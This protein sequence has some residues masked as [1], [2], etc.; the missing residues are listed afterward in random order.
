MMT[1]KRL[2]MTITLAM[3]SISRNIYV[4][5]CA[6]ICVCV[7]VCIF[8]CIFCV[9]K[10]FSPLYTFLNVPGSCSCISTGE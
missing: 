5:V 1:M 6:C 7:C 9:G 3:R 4:C 10:L 8:V 2:M